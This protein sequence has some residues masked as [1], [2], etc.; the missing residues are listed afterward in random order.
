MKVAESIPKNPYFKFEQTCLE[1]K[2][3]FSELLINHSSIFA[4]SS[5]AVL[6]EIGNYHEELHLVPLL[7]IVLAWGREVSQDRVLGARYLELMQ[8]LI[9]S[10]LLPML[11][12]DNLVLL[13]D[14]VRI[15]HKSII[16]RIRSYNE[17]FLQKCEDA[18]ALYVNFT[19]WASEFSIGYIQPA[20]DPDRAV[21]STRRLSYEKYIEL[22]T[23]LPPRER[24]ITKLFYLG[25]ARSLEDILA[26]KIDQVNFSQ[27]Y[28]H[29]ERGAIQYPQ[30]VL[31]EIKTYLK[32]RVRGF[33]FSNMDSTDRINHTI[34]YRALKKAAQKVGLP[35]SFSYKN[36]VKEI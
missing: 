7:S 29:F 18:I 25:G 34:P 19:N 30:H 32:G 36:L 1:L 21:A 11:H 6:A 20:T 3:E 33:V 24:I 28:I 14:Y 12:G 8:E 2:P 9:S 23:V 17:W 16:N 4:D 27:G 31:E 13:R 15:G 5:A 22:L 35:S 26:L 10:H